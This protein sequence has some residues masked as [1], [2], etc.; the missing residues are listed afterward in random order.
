MNR[1]ADALYAARSDKNLLIQF[2]MLGSAALDSD[3]QL[4]EFTV[5]DGLSAAPSPKRQ[6]E[7]QRSAQR[8]WGQH[9]NDLVDG[10]DH[11]R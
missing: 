4:N 9:A 8:P 11:N 6:P 2:L 1:G 5:E 10:L 7:Q 3:R